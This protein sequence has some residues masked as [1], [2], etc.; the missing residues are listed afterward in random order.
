MVSETPDTRGKGKAEDEHQW[1]STEN[2]QIRLKR[3]VRG[4]G[5]D[6]RQ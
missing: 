2:G 6:V 4:D 1:G 3:N 5:R